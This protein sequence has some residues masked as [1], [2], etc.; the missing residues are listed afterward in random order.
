MVKGVEISKSKSKFRRLSIQIANYIPFPINGNSQVILR[1]SNNL[2]YKI[3]TEP[4][5]FLEEKGVLHFELMENKKK[6]SFKAANCC[7]RVEQSCVCTVASQ[8]RETR[9]NEP[10]GIIVE[11]TLDSQDSAQYTSTVLQTC[12][13]LSTPSIAEL[14]S[15]LV[16]TSFI[17]L[18]T[19]ESFLLPINQLLESLE[20]KVSYLKKFHFLAHLENFDMFCLVEDLNGETNVSLQ[21][22]T[23]RHIKQLLTLSLNV[24][25]FHKE[26][27]IQAPKQ[28][29]LSAWIFGSS[30]VLFNIRGFC[31]Q[32]GK[33]SLLVFS[34]DNE[35]L[36][37]S[38]DSTE[39]MV[40]CFSENRL[41]TACIKVAA[42][43]KYHVH[44]CP[45]SLEAETDEYQYVKI[46]TEE[47]R[48]F[49]FCDDNAIQVFPEIKKALQEDVTVD[50]NVDDCLI[51]VT[52]NVMVFR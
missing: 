4:D 26:R 5:S 37:V 10:S 32:Q 35:L 47:G 39:E 8:F 25:A 23:I 45:L 27:Q 21:L 13:T 31:I 34:F 12:K 49:K 42:F 2:Y 6:K 52:N 20:R 9:L 43:G 11:S 36:S 14:E 1:F 24:T 29:A 33:I 51:E 7:V 41:V 50:T 46:Y 38:F 44:A 48:K 18:A 22:I 15:L 40:Q 28:H 30:L 16:I 17:I 3:V 19:Q